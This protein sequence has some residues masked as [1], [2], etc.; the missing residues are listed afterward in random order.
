M[1]YGQ[2]GSQW[3][4]GGSHDPWD[5][6]WSSSSGQTPD[7]A[8]LAEQS[9][10]RNR[11]RR[12][13]LI[14]GGALA[15]VGIGVAVAV[16]V[17]NTDNGSSTANGPNNPPVTEGIP[18]ASAK[19]DPSFAPTSAPPPL[20]P[21]DFISSS[22][23]DKAPISPDIL[24]PG[25]QLTKREGVVYRKGATASTK[26]CASAVQG[27]LD[28]LLTGND[29]TRFMRVTYFRDQVATTIGVALFDTEA[30]ATKV[31]EDW[32]KVSTIVSLSGEDVPVFCRTTV[33][34]TTANSMGRYAYFTLSGFTDGKDVTEKDTAV[35]TAGDDLAQS[36]YEQIRRRGETQAAA[37]ANGQ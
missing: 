4:P 11:R 25:S 15:T 28:K 7:W 2:G 3:S 23:K 26:D 16:A 18:S 29:C 6:Q 32:D 8:S 1:S 10:S 24:F 21:K 22:G 5:N 12:L 20:N 31:K 19:T 14:V 37:A 35:F 33:C 17:V 13:L 27:T 36:T 9:E 30:Q 34:R